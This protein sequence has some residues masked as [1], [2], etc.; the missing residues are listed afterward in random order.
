M[1]IE[2]R[3]P[4][5]LPSLR[6]RNVDFNPLFCTLRRVDVWRWICSRK[7][8]RSL[9][10]MAWVNKFSPAREKAKPIG[11]ETREI[12]TSCR[13]ARIRSSA[14]RAEIELF[15]LSM[16]ALEGAGIGSLF[17]WIWALRQWWKWRS[18]SNSISDISFAFHSSTFLSS[19]AAHSSGVRNSQECCCARAWA[20]LSTK[21]FLLNEREK[22]A[23]TIELVDGAIMRFVRRSRAENPHFRQKIPEVIRPRMRSGHN[24]NFISY[25]A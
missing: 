11:A 18:E 15:S 7:Q 13:R 17:L 23:I 10:S 2:A 6:V 21:A 5:S 24:G 20:G 16:T 3:P 12:E 1:R 25:Q 9:A 4:G 8:T 22:S 19:A 14:R